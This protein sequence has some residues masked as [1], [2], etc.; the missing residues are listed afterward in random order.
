MLQTWIQIV[1]T[2][3]DFALQHPVIKSFHCNIETPVSDDFLYPMM[4][5]EKGNS[6]MISG[7]VVT[8]IT[9]YFL[10][11]LNEGKTND[12][13][14][15]SDTLILMENFFTKYFEFNWDTFQFSIVEN[16]FTVIPVK[17]SNP[18]NAAGH[19]TIFQMKTPMAL[20]KDNI[21]TF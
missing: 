20:L 11:K 2:L 3:Q 12:N 5:V 9:V 10:D 18:D 21:P 1:S 6:Y 15:L 19:K 7:E 4:V 13:N 17:I 16:K 8:D 14:I